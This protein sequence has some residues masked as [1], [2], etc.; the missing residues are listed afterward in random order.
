[1]TLTP[2]GFSCVHPTALDV[3]GSP[4]IV[5]DGD[6]HYLRGVRSNHAGLTRAERIAAGYGTAQDVADHEKEMLQ[7]W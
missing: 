6:R 4:L 2:L 7:M 3:S 1:M 5:D